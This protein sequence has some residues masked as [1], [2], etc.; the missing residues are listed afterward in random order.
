MESRI[1]L[2]LTSEEGNLKG[3]FEVYRAP[4]DQLV[5]GQIITNMMIRNP[6]FELKLDEFLPGLPHLHVSL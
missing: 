5:K 1:K 2:C 3:L 6:C 4:P